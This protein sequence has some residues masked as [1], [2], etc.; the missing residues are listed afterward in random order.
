MHLAEHPTHC[1]LSK[2][3]TNGFNR[4]NRAYALREL[5]HNPNLQPMFHMCRRSTAAIPL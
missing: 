3:G 2:D 4:M 5:R 1:V